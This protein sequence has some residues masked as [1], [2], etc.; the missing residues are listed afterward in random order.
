MLRSNPT[1]SSTLLPRLSLMLFCISF[2]VWLFVSDW[3][4][5]RIQNIVGP[6]PYM[7]L[8]SVLNASKCYGG[9]GDSV[10]SSRDQCGYQY[11]S[12]LLRFI[13]F[14]SLDSIELNTLAAT[15]FISVLS[16]VLLVAFFSVRNVHQAIMALVLVTSPGSWLLFERGNFDLLIFL[17]VSFAILFMHTRFSF[18]TIL[19]ISITALMKFYTL[20]ILLL[21]ILVQKNR[22]LRLWAFFALAFIS[23][24]VL[25][26]IFKAPGFPIPT[27]VAFG[28]LS[29]GLW[30]NFFAWRF[31]IPFEL[32]IPLLYLIGIIAFVGVTLFISHMKLQ[33]K[34]TV[35]SFS[36]PSSSALARNAFLVFSC[37]YFSCFLAGMNYDYRLIYLVI[38]LLLVDFSFISKRYSVF[39]LIAKIGALW[40]T[41]FFFGITGPIH[42]S[43]AVFGNLCQ[44]VIA[45]HLLSATYQIVSDSVI[46]KRSSF[47]ESLSFRKVE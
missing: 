40:S 22:H 27:F 9:I 5:L 31:N 15:L 43:L 16:I 3:W 47:F 45:I 37:T 24:L 18:I 7:D 39:F 2:Y 20:P 28:L 33:V 19:M 23:F 6:S 4:P 21:Y 34:V 29:P 36:S 44:L 38:A 30:V 46:F 17:L 14:F 32:G 41:V 8:E 1:S 35:R 26:D 10:Y 12:F 11:G 13:N 25:I 42:V